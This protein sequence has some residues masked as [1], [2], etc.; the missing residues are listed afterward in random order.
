[1]AQ[2]TRRLNPAKLTLMYRL[3]ML[4][5]GP[6]V[7]WWGRLT[8]TGLDQVPRTGPLL[9][10]ANHDSHWDPVVIGVAARPVRQ[11]RALAKSALWKNPIMAWVL[12][13]MGQI[14]IQRGTSDTDALQNAVD[15]LRGGHCIGVFPEGTIS[16]GVELR[17]RSGAGRIAQSVP[18]ATIV[19][20]RVTGST[21]IVRFP[22]R[23]RMRVDFWVSEA[24][25]P[26]REGVYPTALMRRM[27]SEIR[28]G[29]PFVAAGRRR[30]PVPQ[31]PRT[32]DPQAA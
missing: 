13:G 10:I 28:D 30:K 15:E 20:C 12:D 26:G 5:A 22:K 8:V 16:R 31:Q 11:I 24:G 32:P 7:R 25:K 3:V 17:A 9:L 19:S 23:P 21:D 18:E 27:M 14:P 2:N 6:I 1:M 29:A 4:I